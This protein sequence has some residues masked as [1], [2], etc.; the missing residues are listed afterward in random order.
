MGLVLMTAICGQVSRAGEEVD[1]G[2]D[3]QPLLRAHCYECHGPKQ[4]MN[5]FRL[6]QRR[7]AMRG[8][9]RAMIGPGNS[10]ASLM[11]LRLISDQLGPQMPP[12]GPLEDDQIDIIKR[13]IDQGAK[14][15][16]ELAS[17]TPPPPPDPKATRMMELL[18]DGDRSAFRKMLSEDPKIA[19]L[20]G[21]GGST[22]LMY[23]VLY[24]DLDDVRLLLDHGT[25]PNARNEAGATALM[26][27]VDDLEKTRLLLARGADVN[28]KSDDGRSALAIATSR[29][30]SLDVV[31]LLLDNG[32]DP[33]AQSPSYK[34]TLTPLAEA[35]NVGGESVVRL[36][37]E[38]GADVKGAGSGPLFGATDG[39]NTQCADLLLPSADRDAVSQALANLGP[40]FANA[41]QHRNTALLLQLLDHGADV[42][43][44]GPGGYSVLMELVN[45][46]TFPLESI[47]TLIER[48]AD[49]NLTT[50]AGLTPLDLARQHGQTPVVDLL[51][52]AGA[53]LG[54]ASP[55]QMILPKR[56]ESVRA[57]LA[58]SMPLLQRSDATFL[59]KSGCVSCHNNS[60]TMMTV[61]AARGAGVPVDEGLAS[62]QE[63]TIASYIDVWRERSLQGL[64]IP[65]DSDTVGP[66]M[67][68][69]AAA[70]HSPSADTD[71]QARYLL[72]RQTPEGRWRIFAHRPPHESSDIQ[73]TAAS[74]RALQV[75]A[76][77]TRRDEY[78]K[79][80]ERARTWMK[81]AQAASTEDRAYQ[82]LGL[83]WAGED[84]EALRPTA[85]AL[86]SE[87]RADG[88]W[89]QIPT[90]A[91]DAYATGQALVAL[92][93]AGALASTDP[94]Y[95]RGVDYLMSTQL[96]DGSWHVRSRS[97]PFQP[98]F[99][100]DF[101]HGKDQWISTAATN[102]AAMA[103]IPAAGP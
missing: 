69:L 72:S 85:R 89:G 71:A 6:D 51:E 5:G 41:E 86:L 91:S 25:D 22:P 96:E 27:A 7:E 79:A 67:V 103:L 16:D 77:K 1:F 94:A 61:A 97:V 47:A 28:A 101:P 55:P 40:P 8:G 56:A 92:K 54:E 32:A 68:G 9:T 15:P 44:R 81:Q 48:G 39:N 38:R 75:Y 58:R 65:G 59:R 31:R 30:S 21:T 66:I 53:K 93:E 100:S 17:E 42:N 87:Q 62:T 11:V 37:I 84:Q 90:L 10:E 36:L 82:L 23:A 34:G 46:E 33:S 57:A 13:W 24:G 2:R 4:Q 19:S 78:E 60:M 26:W 50:E 3:V 52:K 74:V 88:G 45:S 12:S 80:I 49:L 99:E 70:N 95:R 43:A 98:Y 73:A 18:R 20:K 64:G 29:Y 83:R 76:P 102:W 35:A 63:G 14:W